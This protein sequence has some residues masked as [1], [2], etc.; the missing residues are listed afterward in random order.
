MVTDRFSLTWL[1]LLVLTVLS[2]GLGELA[3]GALLPALGLVLAA[4]KGQLV[5]D[6]FMGLG[7]APRLW[8]LIMSGYL[9]VLVSALTGL[10]LLSGV[11]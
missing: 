2:A 3:A 1:V 4:V 11:G 5:L 7:R 9:M 10:Y 8:R 6:V